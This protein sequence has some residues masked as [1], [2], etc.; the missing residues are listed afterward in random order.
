MKLL[1]VLLLLPACA[2]PADTFT[3]GGSD[4]DDDLRPWTGTAE[5]A[6]TDFSG[7]GDMITAD[8][9]WTPTAHD[10]DGVEYLASG[11]VTIARAQP[12]CTIDIAPSTHTI[13]TEDGQTFLRV[14]LDGTYRGFAGTFWDVVL[15]TTCTPQPPVTM[16]TL[17]STMWLDAATPRPMTGADELTGDQT[18]GTFHY[19]WHFTR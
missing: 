15:T 16:D 11:T 14:D 10:D 6:Y 19:T 13:G 4:D 17:V 1:P 5:V 18:M 3:D 2:G 9:T 12:G 8:V 7:N